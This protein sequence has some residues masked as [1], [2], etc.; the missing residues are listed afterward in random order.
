MRGLYVQSHANFG[1][2]GFL[3]ALL[4]SFFEL[5]SGG[6]GAVLATHCLLCVTETFETAYCGEFAAPTQKIS[7]STTTLTSALITLRGGAGFVLSPSDNSRTV[8]HCLA[9]K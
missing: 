4:K 2:L 9:E 6:L 1:G 8:S 3:Q 7:L 5:I